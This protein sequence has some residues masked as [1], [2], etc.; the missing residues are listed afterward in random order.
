MQ[1]QN[2]K[3]IQRCFE[4]AVKGMGNVAPNPLVGSVIVH[5]G[6]IIGEG[7]HELYGTH[8]AEVNAVNSVKEKDRHLLK[9]A[10]LYVNLE[11]C[12]HFGRTPPCADLIVKHQIPNVVIA[13]QD[14]FEKVAGKGI[15]KLK[16]AGINVTLGVLEKEAQELNKRFFTFFIKK[17]PYI[18]LKWA[19][20]QDGFF[21]KKDG[22]QHW[23]S[24]KIA[25]RLTHKWRTEEQAIMVGTHTAKVDNPQLTARLWKGQNP[26]R[27]VL[28]KNLRLK[29]DLHIYDENAPT[30]VF[31]EGTPRLPQHR[32]ATFNDE[33]LEHILMELFKQNIQS[34]I[35][36][37]GKTL[38]E[39]FL[40]KD[41]WDEARIFTGNVYFRDGIQ[42]PKLPSVPIH[43][44]TL[45]DNLLTIHRNTT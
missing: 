45:G 41:L 3:Y 4:L 22:Q 15:Q 9:E 27:I 33:L 12:A 40:A 19:Q 2:V 8:H 17:R 42:A 28:D 35:V 5:Q 10:T 24:N 23:I 36:E 25:K 38:L 14:P 29:D 7:Y 6:R 16:D 37:G 1:N 32:Q 20:T 34:V 43:R 44:T 26:L 18:I 39:S 30:W 31:T 21:A 11:P 13:C